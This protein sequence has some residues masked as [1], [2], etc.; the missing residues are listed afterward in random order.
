MEEMGDAQIDENYS[1]TVS[2]KRR[3]NEYENEEAMI[4]E[5]DK[6]N[7]HTMTD[8]TKNGWINDGD[9]EMIFENENSSEANIEMIAPEF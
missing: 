7:F 6:G 2:E 4:E 3:E 8:T 5:T 9:E 1:P